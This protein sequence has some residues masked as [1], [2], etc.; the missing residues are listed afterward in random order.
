MSDPTEIPEMPD[1]STMSDDELKAYLDELRAKNAS[2]NT[3]IKRT[4]R[5]TEKKPPAEKKGYIEVE[6]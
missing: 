1:F 6:L 2:R 4:P 5:T 3:A